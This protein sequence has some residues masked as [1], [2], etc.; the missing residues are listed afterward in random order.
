MGNPVQVFQ[1]N[2]STR[3]KSIKWTGRII[4]LISLFILVVVIL[5]I[6]LAQNP[7][8]N[9]ISGEYNGN[10]DSIKLSAYHNKKI[11]GFKDFLFKREQEEFQKKQLKSINKTSGQFIR[12]AFYTPWSGSKSV[13]SLERYGNKIN[14]I[15]PEWFFIDTNNNI[16]LQT[17]ID[18]AGLAQ[19]RQKNLRIM[20][21]LTNF[22]SSKKDKEGKLA[23]DFDGNLIHA[24]LNDTAKQKKFI[25]QL[26][27][28]LITYNFQGINIDF[29]EIKEATSKPLSRFQKNLYT[30]LHAKNLVVT[31]DVSAMNDDYDYEQLS[32]YNDYV[33]LMA[34][35]ESSNATGP[36][37]IS[38]QK[39]VEDAVDQAAKKMD[40]K[41]IILGLAGYGYDWANWT[42]K[43]GEPEKEVRDQTYAEAIDHA[44]ASNAIIDFD[45]DNYNLHYTYTE[46][47]Y[48][49]Q[50]PLIKHD[51]WFTDAA[52]TFNIMRFA[53]EYG[54]AGTA[55]WRLGSEDPRIWNF[56][57][58][59]LD[60][61]ALQKNPFNFN[62]FTEI[63]ININQKP[64]WV[65]QEGGEILNILGSPQEGKIKI[66]IDNDEQLMAEQVYTQLPSGYVY[67]KSGEDTSEIGTGHKI[68]LTF[69]DGPD[70]EYTPKI[71]DILEKEKI[72]ATFFIVGLAAEKNLPLL[73]RIY[74]DGFEIG[75][76]TFTHH[77]IAT[78]SAE[79]AD[80]ELKAT[81]LLIEAVTGHSTILFRAPYNAD[82]EPQTFDEIEPLARS[83]KDNY[84]TVGESIDPNDWDPN[85]NADSIV[86]RTIRIAED[87]NG[88]II[89]LHDAGGESRQATVDA[90]PRIIKYFRDKGC[91]FT[92]VADLMGKTKNDI[93]P[94]VKKGWASAFNY[95]FV[96]FIYWAG[97][98]IFSLF[99][100]GIFLSIGRIIL[101]ALLAW[102]QKRKETKA[103]PFNIPAA[104][105]P[106]VSIIVP[107]FNEQINAAQTIQSLLLQD[108][109]NMQVVFVD[110][111]STDNTFKIVKDAFK[112]N[113]KVKVFTKSNGGKASAL[114]VG[115]EKAGGEFV[116]CIDADTQLKPDAV[117]L[118]IKKFFNA[119]AH[120]KINPEVGAVAGNVKVGNERN[121]I[122]K[123][124]SIEYITSQN[125]D[126]RAFA[127]LDCITVIPGAIG[128]FRKEAVIKAGGFTSDTLAED[129][130]L[131]MRLHR[132]GYIIRNCN[133]AIS[134]T[135]APETMRQFM[136]QRFR[137][138][139]GVMQCFWKHR[140]A[141][142][143]PRY[144]NFGMIA[145]P[146]ILIFQM[147]LPFLA[148]LADLVL[149]I[150]LIAAAFNIIPVSTGHIVLYYLIF[151]LVDMAG[152]AL[153]FAYEKE[154]YKKLL[155]MIPQRFI[156]RQL[157]YYILFK[158]FNKA[159]KGEMQGW[160]I[161]K[162]T[163]NVKNMDSFKVAEPN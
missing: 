33:I 127:Y 23:A 30:A 54:L 89:L 62:L 85:N 59:D 58:L 88:N 132:N 144:K 41:K 140:D 63:P 141:V 129:C 1:T 15:F 53:D 136:K 36:G 65:G 162:R 156:Y 111:G 76:H 67:E 49:T 45:N 69:D 155:W 101:M 121:M 114:N 27:D 98:I 60:N 116:V 92:T 44:R 20:P 87:G 11:K 137:W 12:A 146:H 35:D 131:T 91:V 150:S 22:N 145:L 108:Y 24:I 78:M 90:L 126:R 157:M 75:N 40:S 70:D 117:S 103:V 73:K 112:A 50:S 142:L 28:T 7:S 95:F 72:A 113:D 34:Y 82:S 94:P 158:S 104:G 160:G 96:E 8:T 31:Q 152:A 86:A 64:S 84:I 148:P 37:P 138:S 9:V 97:K 77:N 147:I 122:T 125:F 21:M 56:Y 154:D 119:G 42:N 161:L 5:A 80:I 14:V 130:D 6:L 10:K 102:L 29:E 55:L 124:Q 143:N 118:L 71:L 110:D 100:I 43:D 3:W 17:R 106:F 25:Q 16:K 4:F 47:Q 79:R 81:R 123:W 163:G 120:T 134:Y 83:K 139:F 105:Q 61:Y 13:P 109:Q 128:A 153:A 107:A 39:W 159:L 133:E 66:E 68:I 2:N 32:N 19:M 18:S 74:Q 57:N 135:E 48:S 149:L 46:K 26:I 51:V 52:T 38:D 151:S 115:I 93:M 99:L